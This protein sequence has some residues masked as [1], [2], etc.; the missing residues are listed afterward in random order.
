MVALLGTLL[1]TLFTFLSLA[2]ARYQDVETQSPFHD[3]VKP[4]MV[5]KVNVALYV[6]SRCPDAVRWP[7]FVRSSLILL[8]ACVRLSSRM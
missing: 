7:L 3:Q 4:E 1:V 5:K 8:S 2:F 6:M